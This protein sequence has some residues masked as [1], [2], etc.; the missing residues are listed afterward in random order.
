MSVTREPF[1]PDTCL[2][3]NV[4]SEARRRLA[5]VLD[6]AVRDGEVRIRRR[7]GSA[8]VLRPLT[9][10]ERARSPLDLPAVEGV[11]VTLDDITEAL[12]DSRDR[13]GT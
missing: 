7:D 11:S 5:D 13:Y 10:P 8:F 12:R 3:V 1:H 4:H 6:E 9:G 2:A